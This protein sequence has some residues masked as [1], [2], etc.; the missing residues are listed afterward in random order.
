MFRSNASTN[1]NDGSWV[2]NFT[3]NESTK[4]LTLTH[5]GSTPYY[6][7]NTS[8]TTWDKVHIYAIRK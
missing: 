1:V 4:V 3:F 5:S 8:S 7:F 6:T 2:F